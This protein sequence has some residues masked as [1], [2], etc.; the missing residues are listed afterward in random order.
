MGFLQE[1]DSLSPFLGTNEVSFILYGLLYDYPFSFDQDGN[2]ASNLITS[3]SL[4]ASGFNWT[5][6]VRQGV[7][8]SDGSQLT[9]EDVNFTWNYD[10]Q[11]LGDLWA[12][13]PYFNQVVQCTPQTRPHCG[14]VVYPTN[15]WNVTVYFQR[16]FVA[17]RALMAPIVQKAQWQNITPACAGGSAGCKSYIYQNPNPIGTGPFMA[18]PNI[19]DQYHNQHQAGVYIHVIR[20][21]NYHPVGNNVS[22]SDDI[23]IQ[24]IYIQIFQ[25]PESMAASLNSGT[26]QLAQ[27][28]PTSIGAVAGEP[29]V[30]TQAALQAVQV[31]NYIGI[32]QID[33]A[34]PDATLDPARWDMNVRR[35]LA[36]ATNKDY[37]IQRFYDGQG[38]RGSSLLSPVTPQWWYDPVAGGDNLTFNVVA[39]NALL[40]Q[41]GYAVWT[42]G[43]FG[44]GYREAATDISVSFQASCYQCA[45]PPNVT[46]MIPAG[47]EL[48]FTLA[49]RPQYDYPE[50]YATAQYL[51]QQYA[52]IGIQIVI[53]AETT[54][55]VFRLDVYSGK[56]EMYI[57][58]WSGDPDPN[59]LLSMQSSWTLNGWNDNSWNN[60]SYNHLYLAQLGDQDI[61][62]RVADVQAAEKIQYDLAPDII[63]LYPYGEWAMRTDLWQGWGDWGAHRYR[64]LNV[65]WGANPLFF[66][67]TCPSCAPIQQNEPPTSPVI[68]SSRYTSRYVNVSFSVNATS[69]DPETYDTINFTWTWGDGSQT[70]C[71]AL[72][73]VANCTNERMPTGGFVATAT[74]AYNRTTN[75]TTGPYVLN[76][77]VSDG[78]TVVPTQNPIYVNVTEP[79]PVVGWLSGIITDAMTSSPIRGAVVAV[80]PGNV[81][82]ST[83]PESG[84]Y[85]ITLAP[86]TYTATA[87]APFYSNSAPTQVTVT[88]DHT[89]SQDFQLVPNVGWVSGTVTD[90]ATGSPISGAYVHVTGS[91]GGE[92]AGS[93]DAQG[94]FNLTLIPDSYT[95]NFSAS[96]YLAASRSGVVVT[97]LWATVV[98]EDLVPSSNPIVLQLTP[99]LAKTGEPVTVFGNVTTPAAGTWVL[100]FGDG[101]TA[102]G[103][104]GAGT[105][106]ISPSH[107][108]VAM[109]QTYTVSL[110]ATSYRLAATTSA[111][112]IVDGTAPVTTR[113]LTGT[114]T[115]LYWYQSAV[116]VNLSAVD[117]MSGVAR[118]FFSVDGAAFAVYAGNFTVSTEGN[119]LV[120]YYSVDRVG[121]TEPRASVQFGVDVTP[122][123]LKLLSPASGVRLT[124]AGVNVSWNGSD[125]LSGILRYQV[126]VDD[127]PRQD[128]GM[129]TSFAV[130][131]ADGSH[132]ITVWAFDKAGNNVSKSITLQIDT[133]IFSPSG[134]YAGVPT[135]AIIAAAVVIA[136]V[137]AW[138]RRKRNPPTSKRDEGA[139]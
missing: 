40:N 14:A 21:P 22:G 86:G 100:D 124:F 133:N 64:Q 78:F 130:D 69:T 114:R 54:E 73:T 131:L 65:P 45:D 135:Y 72:Q 23:H 30:L 109:S 11:N 56:I 77:T 138:R 29:N 7:Y 39:A 9:A 34:S 87:S 27:F 37:I 106:P 15:P 63:T 52:Q 35:A 68:N 81:V 117:G 132:T 102:R 67:L 82:S 55:D 103:T 122:P 41:S 105:T 19:Y 95:V 53:K 115:Y 96:G 120:W 93:T 51:Q 60:A 48:N 42:G 116:T 46:K 79:A 71:P 104:H 90:S 3:A 33:A 97:S 75:A 28:T 101:T 89:T 127:G 2:Y 58:F 66:D 6:T 49:T 111:R 13:E 121:N 43:S 125:D 98:G 1:V 137:V 113:S 47:T 76:V 129:N 83:T 110:S 16:P 20:N 5:Y 32:S 4:D 25:D 57:W 74:H 26:L 12:Y 62:Q 123:S 70:Y 107:V 84:A 128:V 31:W 24:N 8:W 88:A 18:D 118:T 112:A 126:S 50:E 91:S 139:T 94:K 44:L 134:P 80:M 99:F 59:Y 119:H 17:G 38:V 85:N 108:Y 36:M 136:A 92:T 10:S 61:V